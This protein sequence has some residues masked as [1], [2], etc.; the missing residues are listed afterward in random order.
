MTY[1][2]DTSFRIEPHA[3]FVDMDDPTFITCKIFNVKCGDIVIHELD[4]FDSMINFTLNGLEHFGPKG[5]IVRKHART[6]DGKGKPVMV[7]T[8]FVIVDEELFI[9]PD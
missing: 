5:G 7:G 9:K 3:E 8:F 6:W 1:Q 2:R 4:Y